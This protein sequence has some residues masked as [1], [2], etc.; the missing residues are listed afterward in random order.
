MT[1]GT[2]NNIVQFNRRI[3]NPDQRLSSQKMRDTTTL[4]TRHVTIGK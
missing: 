4:T 1:K 3:T 2:I